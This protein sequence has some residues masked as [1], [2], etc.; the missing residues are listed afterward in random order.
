MQTRRKGLRNY[1]FVS[2]V[3][4]AFGYSG[5]HAQPG[6]SPSEGYVPSGVCDGIFLRKRPELADTMKRVLAA[7]MVPGGKTDTSLCSGLAITM[8]YLKAEDGTLRPIPLG[9]LA[10]VRRRN[11]RVSSAQLL[12]E[13]LR[14][15][16]VQQ[17]PSGQEAVPT[18]SPAKE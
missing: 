9:V 17:L 14:V 15:V 13:V 5:V 1:F 2:M 11:P 6:K 7:I 8:V 12:K 3:I 16:V 18:K 10:S 4:L